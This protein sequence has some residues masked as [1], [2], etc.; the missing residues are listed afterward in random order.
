[1]SL[2]VVRIG[3]GA[4]LQDGGRTGYRRFGVPPGG[5]FDRES[6]ALGNALL[7]NPP[8]APAIEMTLLGGIF[9]AERDLAFSICGAR[10]RAVCGG[11]TG[12]S[13]ARFAARAG[14]RIEVGPFERGVR[15]YLCMPGGFAGTPVLGSIS[16]QEVRPCSRLE[17]AQVGSESGKPLRL[18]DEPRSLQND[19]LMF[20]PADGIL[21]EIVSRLG[22]AT[23]TI[24]LQSDRRG[25]RLDGFDPIE[26]EEL[27]SEPSCMGAIQLTPSGQLLIIGP[28]GPTIGGYPKLGFIAEAHHSAL[29][30]LAPGNAVR[31]IPATYE[32]ASRARLESERRLKTAVTQ[33]GIIGL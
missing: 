31:L 29:G 27:P 17:P 1:M 18:A 9:E 30:Q 8:D 32:E 20:L 25:V 3:A 24:S 14:D 12:A 19:G 33:L 16:G 22:Q 21:D 5:A 28:D 2:L 7:G 11:R 10:C 13:Q 26:M 6:L 23:L 15:A 4:T